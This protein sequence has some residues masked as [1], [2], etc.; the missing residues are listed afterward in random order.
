M[1]STDVKSTSH[2]L[3]SGTQIG[4]ATAFDVN[5]HR[6]CLWYDVLGNM[7]ILT[8]VCTVAHG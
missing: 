5:V 2:P 1:G 4:S 3:Y 6:H 7:S 8:A